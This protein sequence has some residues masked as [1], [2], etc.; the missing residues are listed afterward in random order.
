MNILIAMDSF[1]GCL[2]TTELAD[3]ISKGIQDVSMDF[4]IEKIPIADGGEGTYKTL[5]KGIGGETVVT[6]VHGPL[7]NQIEAEYGILED[8]TAIIEMAQSSGL[9]LVPEI[10]RNPMNTTTYGVGELIKDAIKK[11]SRNFII[12]IGGSAT[13]DAGIGMLNALGYEFK[14]VKGN[15]LQPNGSSLSKIHT[16]HTENVLSELEE[17]RFL[18]ACDVD[19]PLYGPN[20]A[21]HVYAKQKGASDLQVID[22]DKGLE[23][24]GKIVKE[25]RNIDITTIPGSGAAGGLGGGFIGFLN[26]KLESG[27]S[28]IF[29][30]LNIE[31]KI[32]Q[33]D[34]IITG[35][36]KLDFQTVM[37][38]APM[39]IAQ[40]AKKHNKIVIALAGSI[41]EDAKKGHD[42]GI[43]S[44]FSIIDSPMTLDHAMNKGNA[45]RLL[46]NQTNEL[47]RLIHKIK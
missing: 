7:F 20:G 39:G 30:K 33:A 21:A 19:N 42:F 43:T 25:T 24:F 38:K 1:K 29:D 2:S 27:S 10:F 18:V 32:E 12:G 37:G 17:C 26:A 16:V 45:T 23:N 4:K 34:I 3:I 35:E 40:L 28:I 11:G 36:G 46:Y 13:N 8:K 22:L 14:D 31:S 9:P 44:M 15:T 47:F 41:T 5:V 6:K